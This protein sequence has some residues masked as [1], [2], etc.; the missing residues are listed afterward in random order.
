MARGTAATPRCTT[1][2]HPLV[3]TSAASFGAR[4]VDDSIP[5]YLD[6]P[7]G[8]CGDTIAIHVGSEHP[9]TTVIRAFRI[10]WYSGTGSRLVWSSNHI[11]V[12]VVHFRSITKDSI[13]SPHWPT[14]ASMHIDSSWEPG[15]YAI[16]TTVGKRLTGIAEFVVRNTRVNHAAIVI[17]SGLTNAAYSTFGG[18]SL[19]RRVAGTDS[20]TSVALQRPLILNGR[21]SFTEYDIPTAQVLDHIG[22]A[23]DPVI[24]T[25]VNSNPSLLGSRA[26]IVVAGHSEYW[27]KSMYDALLKAQSVG[28]NVAVLGANEIYWQTRVQMNSL[29]QPISMFVAR[30][31]A[32]D[33]LATTHPELTTVR[34][35]DA[36]LTN[37][38]AGHLG[39]SYSV[40]RAHGSLQ[41][42]SL[43]N[44]LSGIPGLRPGAVLAGVAAGEVDGPQTSTPMAT[45]S[46]TQI[47]GFGLLK[48]AQ[49][50]VA[51]LGMTYYTDPHGSAVFQ[52]GTT[53][54]PCQLMTSCTT[55]N[56]SRT[57]RKIQW[58]LTSTV[59]R[60]FLH[61]D[62]A[63][64][65]P[66]M[67]ST[68]SLSALQAIL[69]PQAVGSF[70]KE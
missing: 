51:Y 21:V 67:P 68:K 33:P 66:S 1:A 37:D 62:W 18:A 29:G 42:V 60:N 22:L 23:V 31:R 35:R 57:T 52:F 9:A 28:T 13:P 61:R 69:R 55:D 8:V 47:V 65:H 43:P 17:Y 39:E 25:D 14:A 3:S 27:T 64:S 11:R 24:D 44:W 41:I 38:P 48:N 36:P 53:K 5:L 58:G 40:T 19:Y 7:S 30:K 6:R 34:W 12:P 20:A 45:P 70:G 26:E 50:R 49:G 32:A 63:A 46:A 54:W 4:M 15:L 16:T 2:R 10:G 56:T 59:L